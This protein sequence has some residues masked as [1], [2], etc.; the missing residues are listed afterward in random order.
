MAFQGINIPNFV[1]T[2]VYQTINNTSNVFSGSDVAISFFFD[3]PFT[4]LNISESWIPK[5]WNFTGYSLGSTVT[6]SGF[7]MSGAI[8]QRNSLNGKSVISQF[9]YETGTLFK[10]SGGFLVPVTGNAR[11]GL[12]ITG[13]PSGLLNFSVGIFGI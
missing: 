6:G 5:G 7:A 9:T 3:F 2:T 11:V 1:D 8:Y 13:I 10:T 12:D 4:G